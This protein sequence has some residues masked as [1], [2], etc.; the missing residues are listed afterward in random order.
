MILYHRA[1]HKRKPG[2]LYNDIAESRCL[3]TVKTKVLRNG[4]ELM[5]LVQSTPYATYKYVNRY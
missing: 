2:K 3:S 1:K 5:L 4:R